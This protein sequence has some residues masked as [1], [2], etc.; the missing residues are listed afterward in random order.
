M[1]LLNNLIGSTIVLLV[2]TFTLSK[3]MYDYFPN[4][5]G[6]RGIY[7]SLVDE[8]FYKEKARGKNE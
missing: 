5:R 8:Y 3:F 2:G 6:Y 1:K 7:G 4:Q